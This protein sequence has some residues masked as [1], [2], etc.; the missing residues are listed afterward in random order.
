[1]VE[2]LLIGT[3]AGGNKSV[4][5]L[6]EDGIISID[7][8]ILFNTTIKDVPEKYRNKFVQI[9]GSDFGGCG[10]EREKGKTLM[11]NALQN[12]EINLDGLYVPGKHRMV[13]VV[14]S[15][16]GGTGSGSAP[17]IARYFAQVLHI[18]THL[19]GFVGFGEGGRG[20]KNTVSFMQD[21]VES[22]IVHLID[23]SK[24]LK[25]AN[26]NQ[27]RAEKLA[28]KELAA[29][30]AIMTGK[31]LVDSEQNIDD[32]DL[33][34]LINNPGYEEIAYRVIDEK[35]KTQEQF[36]A[37]IKE[38]ISD[39]KSVDVTKPSQ[40]RMGAIFNVPESEYENV[41]FGLSIVK[42]KYGIPFEFFKQIQYV[43]EMPRFV[44]FVCSGVKLP[45]EE[46]KDIH[47]KYLKASSQVS[48]DGDEFYADINTLE[49]DDTDKM[50]DTK[51]ESTTRPAASK[52]S[53]F[54]SFK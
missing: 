30:I 39:S 53:F 43:K 50:F 51:F 28:N 17:V 10:M 49:M 9:N 26:G 12:G 20:L 19:V 29:R 36:N 31:V 11:L 1:M 27:L 7:D 18:P 2:A 48:K 52:D 13:I 6:V 46:I 5:D 45:M 47:E 25:D 54:S 41:D 23:N 42:E 33:F 14:A 15:T 8:M 44:A 35:I 37:I 40:T 4:I 34:K 38:M 3:G 24:F 16:E 22:L 21:I 32:M